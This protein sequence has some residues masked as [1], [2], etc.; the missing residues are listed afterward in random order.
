MNFHNEKTFYEKRNLCALFRRKRIAALKG[1]AFIVFLFVFH[2]L[3][4]RAQTAI[5]KMLCKYD[6]N[7]VVF[8]QRPLKRLP[9]IPQPRPSDGFSDRNN[10]QLA[11]EHIFF[12]NN[13]RIERNVGFGRD[14]RYS[15][16]TISERYRLVNGRR[17]NLAI[18]NSILGP[19]ACYKSDVG[20][21]GLRS[22]NCQDFAARVRTEYDLRVSALSPYTQTNSPATQSCQATVD[23]VLSIIRLK[24]AKFTKYRVLKNVDINYYGNPAARSDKIIFDL[25]DTLVRGRQLIAETLMD[26]EQMQHWANKVVSNCSK[27]GIVTF[28]IYATD[29]P[30]SYFAQGNE[31]T[32]K[33]QCIKPEQATEQKL[34]WGVEI[35]Q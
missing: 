19:D 26:T 6:G 2:G 35:C 29:T 16:E 3:D 4:V 32:K 30:I 10:V 20:T 7:Y 13:D 15:E 18:I 25:R 8:A 33:A 24:G 31:S 21:Y 28:V 14:G 9:F 27:T 22:N 23:S 11:H 17:Y 34:Q 1:S 5:E 12:C